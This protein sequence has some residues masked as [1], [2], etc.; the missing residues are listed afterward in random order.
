MGF[1]RDVRTETKGG[2]G[3]VL[4]VFFISIGAIVLFLFVYIPTGLFTRTFDPNNVI[5]R[6]EW[7]HN[8]KGQYDARVLQ[9]DSFKH[10]LKTAHDQAE[11]T[12]ILV[13]LSAIQTAC[14]ELVTKYNQNSVKINQ[15][16][17]RDRN[18][19]SQLDLNKCE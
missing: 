15:A 2:Y 16:M 8:A 17:F 19:P 18:L 9:V 5:N 4:P 14:R 6:Y 3:I 12:R 10:L 7:F 11:K 1:W 13:E